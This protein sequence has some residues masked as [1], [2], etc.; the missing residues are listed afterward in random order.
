MN[1]SV[2]QTQ[3]SAP[4]PQPLGADFIVH[5]A[6]LP[7]LSRG[8]MIWILVNDEWRAAEVGRRLPG[9][10]Y[11]AKLDEPVGGCKNFVVHCGNFGGKW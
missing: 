8:Q 9:D 4:E 6:K 2:R 7:K 11:W 5:V 1:K 10:V 3:Q